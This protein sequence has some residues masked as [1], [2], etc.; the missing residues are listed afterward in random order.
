MPCISIS[1][2]RQ[3]LNSISDNTPPC[4]TSLLVSKKLHEAAFPLIRI[5]YYNNY[6]YE[7]HI[8]KYLTS[9]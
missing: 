7:Y 6:E 3:T 4:L 8:F 1:S 2:S 9:Y 5:F